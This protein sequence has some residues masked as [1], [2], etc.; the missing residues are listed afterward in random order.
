MTLFDAGILGAIEGLTEFLPISSTAHILIATKL[1]GL[2]QDDFQK[3][4]EIVIQSGAI[5]AVIL[6]YFKTLIKRDTIKTLL[7]AFIPTAIVGFTLYPLIKGYF[8][9]HIA[10][11]AYALIIGGIIMI[12]FEYWLKTKAPTFTQK[13]DLPITNKQAFMI[14]VAQSVAVIPGV[15]RSG[16]TI[17]GGLALGLSRAKI[18]EFSFLL[19]VPTILAATGLDLLKHSSEFLQADMSLLFVGLLSAFVSSLLVIKAFLSFVRRFT[20]IPFGIYRIILGISV[21]FFLA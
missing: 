6:F 9:S 5:F 12:I 4:F 20:F 21:L 16:A 18:V 10:V 3:L 19:A 13:T 2:E 11:S 17:I 15:S 8:L 7:V 1:F 14:G